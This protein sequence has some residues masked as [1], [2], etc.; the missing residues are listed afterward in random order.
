MLVEHLQGL[1]RVKAHQLYMSRVWYAHFLPA[2][3]QA[4][5]LWLSIVKFSHLSIHFAELVNKFFVSDLIY[6]TVSL[7]LTAKC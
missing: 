2:L 1:K 5:P 3:P 6:V 7:A 4:M